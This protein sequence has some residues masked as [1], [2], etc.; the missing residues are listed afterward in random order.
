MRTIKTVSRILLP[1]MGLVIS[2]SAMAAEGSWWQRVDGYVSISA[3]AVKATPDTG[4]NIT[5]SY[6]D[7]DTA[8]VD[9]AVIGGHGRKTSHYLPTGTLGAR[10]NQ[11]ENFTWGLELQG[12]SF[13]DGVS[14]TPLDSPTVTPLP[15]FATFRETSLFK[16]D[17]SDITATAGYSRWNATAEVVAGY[18]SASFETRAEIESF[19]VFTTGNFVNV[20]LSNGAAFKGSGPVAGLRLKYTP[21]QFPVS[22][23]ARYKYS[24]LDGKSDSFGRAVGTVASSPSAPLVGAAT[25]TRNDA[26][27]KA[28]IHDQ[29]YGL[30]YD[31][32]GASVS[33][34]VSVTYTMTKL[35]LNG[36][37]TGGAGFGG[38]IGDLT[39]N[40][41]SSASAED[42]SGK[43][44]GI[45]FTVGV[46]F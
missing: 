37:P 40:S 19:G 29:E 33:S 6:N 25:V 3:A 26:D 38:T 14:T 42:S 2:A 13:S 17:A 27:A 43:W 20:A 46:E 31:F 7:V 45:A 22:V 36:P 44:K 39:T 9:K 12:Y 35:K 16:M 11:T 24:K 10:F 32:G 34:F 30:Q 15:N 28:D 4:G 18:R 8:A 23:V 21:P 5:L 41:F 1:A